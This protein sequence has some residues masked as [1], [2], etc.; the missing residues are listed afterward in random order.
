MIYRQA[1]SAGIAPEITADRLRLTHID[2][3]LATCYIYGHL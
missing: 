3:D 2:M 1:A